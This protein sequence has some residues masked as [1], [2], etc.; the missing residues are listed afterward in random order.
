MRSHRTLLVFLI[1]VSLLLGAAR[2]FLFLN[3]NY[4]ID[5]LARRSAFSYAHSVFQRWT[6]GMDLDALLRWKWGLAVA[7][8]AAMW[9][10]A[11]LTARV[12][13]GDHRYLRVITLLFLAVAGL[14]LMLHLTAVPALEAVSVKLLHA[15]Q[16]PVVLVVLWVALRLRVR[17]VG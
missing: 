15:L 5:H 4:Q 1:P 13:V 11:I 10:L 2:E 12:L 17:P 6:G 3:L 14:A 9:T 7:F 8:I 16:Y